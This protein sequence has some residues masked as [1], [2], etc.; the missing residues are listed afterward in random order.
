MVWLRLPYWLR[1]RLWRTAP[2]PPT[3]H[4]S[5]AVARMLT[6][7]EESE[8]AR[9]AAGGFNAKGARMALVCK[10]MLRDCTELKE[11]VVAVA[12]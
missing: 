8:L 4:A 7:A 10:A 2:P 1:S 9:L 6:S 5:P 3:V 12:A 11:I